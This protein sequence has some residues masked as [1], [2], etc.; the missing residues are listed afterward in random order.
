M[1]GEGDDPAA[2]AAGS[3]PLDALRR[4]VTV[5][6]EGACFFWGD[7]KLKRHFLRILG[8]LN[9]RKRLEKA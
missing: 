6:E 9:H 1:V 3:G 7:V 8:A 5:D 2:A 4:L